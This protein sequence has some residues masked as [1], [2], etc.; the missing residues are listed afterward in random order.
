MHIHMHPYAYIHIPT[1]HI[2]KE[3]TQTCM[4]PFRAHAHGQAWP[5]AKKHGQQLSV[6]RASRSFAK[7][8][9]SSIMLRSILHGKTG[10]EL[11]IG[12]K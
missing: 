11:N 5:Y 2:P 1:P 7:T 3:V 8:G 6:K 9:L 4:I 10:I 12:Q